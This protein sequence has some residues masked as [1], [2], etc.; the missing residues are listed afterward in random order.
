VWLEAPVPGGTGGGAARIWLTAAT[1]TRSN[2]TVTR[3]EVLYR[4]RVESGPHRHHRPA[5]RHRFRT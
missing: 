2:A 5:A 4:T 3:F 1:S